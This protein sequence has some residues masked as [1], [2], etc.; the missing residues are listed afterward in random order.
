MVCVGYS[1]VVLRSFSVVSTVHYVGRVRGRPLILFIMSRG[2]EVRNALASNSIHHTL[3]GNVSISTPVDRTVRHGFGFLHH[4]IGSEIRSVRRRHSLE[5]HLM[6]V[7]SRRGRVYRVVG[8]RRCMAG[9][10]VST[11]LVTNNGKRH[12]H[13]LARGA[14]GPLV[15]M[16]SGYV[17]SCGVSHLLSCNL[18]R[19]SMAI[20]C[21]NSR[22]RR[23]FQ[24]RHSKIGVIAIHR[25]GCLNAV[26]DVGFIR[27]FCGSAILMVGSSLFAGVSFR[28]F[29]LRFYRRSTSVDITTIPCMI[30]I[31]CNIFGL[32]KQRVGNIARGP[33]VD[34]CT[35]TNVC[36][37]G[38]GLLSLVPS[39]VF[40]GTA[41]FVCGL[42]RRKCGIVHCPVDKC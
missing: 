40:F 27:A 21:L 24:R 10:P 32:R 22:V 20:G 36:L 13:P 42:V 7:L 35:G 23:R 39:S 12:L 4:K 28:S 19:V 15:G 18:G 31:P 11:M 37:V 3:V 8:L 14:P 25:P 29:F 38:H 17:V 1:R 41:S 6:P 16:N 30:G 5:V 2:E 33:A 9:L 26:N 34:C